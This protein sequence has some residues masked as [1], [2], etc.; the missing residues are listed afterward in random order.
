MIDFLNSTSLN[1]FLFYVAP[2][3]VA[4]GMFAFVIPSETE[5]RNLGEYV[6]QFVTFSFFYLSLFFWLIALIDRSDVKANLLLYNTLILMAIFIIPCI[7][8]WL[9]SKI[10][11]SGILARIL[12]VNNPITLPWD[13]F[14]LN[15]D[16]A[17]FVLIH[18]KSGSMIGGLYGLNS[19]ASTFPQ[20]QEVYI[21]EV[22]KIDDQGR[23]LEK[24]E[25]T[26]GVLIKADECS[27]IEFYKV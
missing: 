5:R 16:E 4:T 10:L 12:G 6:I 22:W 20:P 2:G 11:N 25:N 9:G 19:F 26:Q 7:L 21:E 15:R 27:H 23:F 14:F 17:C 24:L 1:L 3:V 8:G 13:Y 18:L